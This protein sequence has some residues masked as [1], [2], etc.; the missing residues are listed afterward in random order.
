MNISQNILRLPGWTLC[1]GATLIVFLLQASPIPGMYL[2]FL[3]APLWSV[4]TV[5]LGFL[6]LGVDAVRGR[7]FRAALIFPILWFGGYAVA[8]TVSHSQTPQVINRL[9]AV[10][11][12]PALR[13]RSASQ[14]LEMRTTKNNDV[15]FR[16]VDGEKLIISYGLSTVYSFD[17]NALYVTKLLPRACPVPTLKIGRTPFIVND[18][19]IDEEVVTTK[20]RTTIN[21]YHAARLCKMRQRAEEPSSRVV[22]TSSPLTRNR[23]GLVDTDEQTITIRSDDGAVVTRKFGKAVPLAWLPQPIAG[24]ALSSA[25][26][27]WQCA[28]FFRRDDSAALSTPTEVELTAKALGLRRVSL[29]QRFPDAGWR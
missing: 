15:Y 28:V 22:V 24:C 12:G 3:G 20:S 17:G 10:N 4:V 14:S 26:P 16:T 23:G 21:Y 7:I 19:A 1:F 2:M 6:L 13:W 11:R 5:N 18:G 9:E 8:T 29:R 27:S 25:Q